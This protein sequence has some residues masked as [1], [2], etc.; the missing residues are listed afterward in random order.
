[1]ALVWNGRRTEDDLI[2]H[3]VDFLE[4]I[5]RQEYG[6]GTANI[7]EAAFD[8]AKA[9]MSGWVFATQLLEQ[10]MGKEVIEDLCRNAALIF[11]IDADKKAKVWSLLSRPSVR[12]LTKAEVA[13]KSRQTTVKPKGLTPLDGVYNEFYLHYNRNYA[14]DEY[15]DLVFVT[16]DDRSAAVAAAE[17]TKC[18]TSYNRYKTIH[19]WTFESDWIREEAT[20]VKLLTWAVDWFYLRRELWESEHPLTQLDLEPGDCVTWNHPLLSG[21]FLCRDLRIMAKGSTTKLSWIEY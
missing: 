19:R 10:K 2:E 16:K 20:A 5:L 18:S 17:Q 3:P 9:A 1:M 15:E 4:A 21:D 13:L 6:F 14:T 12:T 8:A 7:D 11:W